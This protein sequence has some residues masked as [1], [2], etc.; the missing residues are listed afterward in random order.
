MPYLIASWVNWRKKH[1]RW[2]SGS[3]KFMNFRLRKF[4]SKNFFFHGYC[5]DKSE[6]TLYPLYSLH[7]I[8]SHVMAYFCTMCTGNGTTAY[9]CSMAITLAF[10]TMGRVRNIRL[11]C[12][13]QLGSFNFNLQNRALKS[14][15]NAL[16]RSA[17]A[18]SDK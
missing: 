6:S 5:L 17:L 1:N 15:I 3:N 14:Q 7:K 16:Y 4:D 10:T 11:D 12:T 18:Y 13:A 8:Y 9:S 2:G